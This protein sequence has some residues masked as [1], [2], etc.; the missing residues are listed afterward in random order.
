M[1]LDSIIRFAIPLEDE[2]MYPLR[3]ESSIELPLYSAM[4]Q[5]DLSGSQTAAARLR[6]GSRPL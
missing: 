1:H 5:M 2:T 3:D 6:P 4:V